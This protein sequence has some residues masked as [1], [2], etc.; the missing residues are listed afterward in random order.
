[1]PERTDGG[2]GSRHARP[3][4]ATEPPAVSVGAFELT[5][6][7]LS[8]PASEASREILR[9]NDLAVESGFPSAVSTNP[10]E[11]ARTRA[12]GHASI[13]VVDG[14]YGSD[15]DAYRLVSILR[16]GHGIG[17]IMLTG[18]DSKVRT[19]ALK[20]GADLCL[21]A[22]VD[23]DEF[24]S[25]VQAVAR[26][27]AMDAGLPPPG[28]DVSPGAPGLE[29]S[30]AHGGQGRWLLTARGWELRAPDGSTIALTA[31]ERLLMSRLFAEPGAIL[32]HEEWVS[33]REAELGRKL[34]ADY[35]HLSVTISRLRKKCSAEGLRLPIASCWNQGYQFTARCA[36][37]TGH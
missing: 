36:V 13:F 22:P 35:P 3:G 23:P 32:R 4:P 1:M 27:C 31:M 2:L 12:A 19:R 5:L 11:L 29:L 9:L 8:P 30:G 17:I 33:Q 25:A 24:R 18:D 37:E 15:Y 10:L 26:R 28:A 34:A 21:S 20:A 6:L 7:L 16:C 14:L